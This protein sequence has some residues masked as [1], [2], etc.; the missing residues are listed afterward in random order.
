MLEAARKI[1]RFPEG[2]DLEQFRR[3]ERTVSAVERRFI[4]LGEAAKRVDPG[5]RARFPE[6]NFRLANLMAETDLS[7][8]LFPIWTR[9]FSESAP[10]CGP[11]PNGAKL[12]PGRK[13]QVRFGGAE[14]LRGPVPGWRTR[15]VSVPARK[16]CPPP[17]ALRFGE[18]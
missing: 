6:I 18:Q 7:L 11:V 15:T 10:Q 13:G 4:L 2:Y 16:T 3:D 8:F 5:F 9:C 1:G 14:M 17:C 12:S